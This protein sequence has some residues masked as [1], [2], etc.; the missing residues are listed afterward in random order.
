[1]LATARSNEFGIFIRKIGFSVGLEYTLDRLRD[2]ATIYASKEVFSYGDVNRLLHAPKPN[3]WGL[4]K[5][6]EHVL[7]VMRS[8]GVLSVSKGEVSV[9]ELG[10]AL[11]ILRKLQNDAHFELSL[12]FL[13]VH[14]LILADGDI[15]LNALAARFDSVD[16]CD[17]A[18]RMLEYKWSVLE[19]TFPTSSRRAAIYQAV[20]IETQDG[21][22]GSRGYGVGGRSA[23]HDRSTISRRTG[24]LQN[25]I[26]R[27]K[28]QIS[29]AYLRKALPRRKAW[30]RSVELIDEAGDLTQLGSSFL[31]VLGNKG[32]GGP[33]CLAVWPLASEL[34]SPV[35]ARMQLPGQVIYSSW[36][37]M[38]LIGQALHL[39]GSEQ[40]V[41]SPA[42]HSLGIGLMVTFLNTFRSL[43][44]SKRI[45][46]KEL[47]GRVAYRCA[48]AWNIGKKAIPPYVDIIAK[49]QQKPAPRIVARSS[50]FAEIALS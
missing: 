4:E 32:L 41:T 9:L 14:A 17:R 18:T 22:P 40:K 3:G 12:R 20:N 42:D 26:D 6:N 47:P 33:S 39:L 48:L 34:T 43:N 25:R 7:D 27:P 29:E 11:G 2:F 13:F 15:F 45:L 36:N 10:E 49:E 28:V 37:F 38:V 21:N 1:M 31:E 24:P 8:F 16:F 23:I 35:F 46:R 44:H 30:A 50:R 19:E 5:S